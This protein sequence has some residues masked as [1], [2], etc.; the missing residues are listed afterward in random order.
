MHSAIFRSAC[1]VSLLIKT[2]E[3][4]ISRSSSCDDPRNLGVQFEGRL[5]YWYIFLTLHAPIL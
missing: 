1:Q 5:K 3:V 2:H 4:F